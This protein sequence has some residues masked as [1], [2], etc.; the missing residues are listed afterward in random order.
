MKATQ[1]GNFMLSKLKGPAYLR[2]SLFLIIF[3]SANCL[4]IRNMVALSRDLL[5]GDHSGESIKPAPQYGFFRIPGNRRTQAVHADG[6]LALDYAQVYFPSRFFDDLSKNYRTGEFDPYK[7]PS[8]YAPF[9]HYL[10]AISYCQLDYGP[11]SLAHLYIQLFLFLVSFITAFLLL[12]IPRHLP[13]GILTVSVGLFITPAGLFWFERGQFSLYVAMAYLFVILGV[14]RRQPLFFLLG[15][16]FA[17]IK[18]TSFPTIFVI[19][20]IFLLASGNLRQLKKN[21][22]LVVPFLAIILLL[23]AV[24]PKNSYYF[25][26]GL[27]QQE[28]FV[29]PGGISLVRLLPVGLVKIM[30]IA[31]IVIGW[32][33]VRK[34]AGNMAECLAFLTGA[35]ILMLTYPTVAFDYSVSTLLGF[36][37]FIMYWAEQQKGEDQA[38]W[39]NAMKYLFLV[40]LL[41]ASYSPFLVKFFKDEYG[42]FWLYGLVTGIFLFVPLIPS[43]QSVRTVS[44]LE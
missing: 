26:Q 12:K 11:A 6:R 18:W 23:L 30:P 27:I 37:P 32:L 16:F 14:L 8:R 3:V 38:V 21:I 19:L 40:F 1:A 34:Y 39:R 4:A 35:G 42:M 5:L 15:G 41:A 2:W 22:L 17:F 9:V 43:F 28:T 25:I 20:S 7:R 44:D 36:I 33:H 24:F 29:S 31:L 10:C 13:L